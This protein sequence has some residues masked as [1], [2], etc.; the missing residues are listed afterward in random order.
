MRAVS[1]GYVKDIHANFV[2]D[3]LRHGFSLGVTPESL[4]GQRVFRNYPSAY[5]ARDSVSDSV[6]ARVDAKRTLV[7]GPW[8][9]V[10]V[11]LYGLYKHFFIFPMGAV[12]KPHQPD[13]MRPT[14]DHSRTGLNAATVMGILGHSLDTYKRVAWLLNK[15]HFMYVSDV[16]DAFM[17][18]PLAPWL[19]PFFLFRWALTD[20]DDEDLLVHTMGDFGSRGLPGTFKIFLVDVV[21]QMA[22]SEFVLTL[23]LVVYVDDAGLIAEHKELVDTEMPVFQK[24][25]KDVCGV[26]WKALKDR[27]GS[28]TPEYI[29]FIWNS[30]NFTHCLVEKKVLAY[31]NTI[32]CAADSVTLSLRDR[33]SLAGKIQRAIMTFPPGAACLLTNCYILMS[34]LIFPWQKRR[35]TAAERADY[36]FVHDLLQLNVGKGYYR[37]DGFKTA[38]TI[39][40]DA[41]KSKGYCGG[42]WISACGMYDYFLYGTSCSRKPIDELEGDVPVRAL[43]RLS[44][45]LHECQVP[46]GIDNQAFMGSARK[47]RSK[48]IRLNVIVKRLFYLQIRYSFIILP[49]YIPTDENYLADHLSRGRVAEFLRAVPTSDFISSDIFLFCCPDAGRT[50]TFDYGNG[51]MN[52]LRQLLDTYSSNVSKDGPSR[53]AGVGGDSQLL[54]IPYSRANILAGLPPRFLERFDQVM[55]NRLADSSM[56]KV[57]ALVH[58]LAHGMPLPQGF[59]WPE[60]V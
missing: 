26:D 55:D 30:R 60:G 42:G 15:N 23:P 1:R 28:Q 2:A 57:A 40:T 44:C 59:Q 52:A 48:V 8:S 7:L 25:S 6:R 20:G 53:G 5:A 22:R 43:E 32:A 27:V 13:V 19:W 47:G 54:S 21:V 4:Q 34:G 29:G 41:C 12:P 37:Y 17:L 33:Q 36:R 3:G 39:L 18:I 58:F 10:K 11:T 45:K 16:A 9:Q 56:S 51:S 24:W 38:P 49:F 46:L 50:V 31:L 35:T 14:S